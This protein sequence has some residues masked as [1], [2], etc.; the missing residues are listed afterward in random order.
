MKISLI[1]PASSSEK[2]FAEAVDRYL[3]RIRHFYPIEV[4]EVPAERGRQS[5]SDVFSQFIPSVARDLWSGRARL[6]VGR[7]LLRR[8]LAAL[9]I[10]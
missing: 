3:K 5:Q 1:W 6:T 8:S 4:V 9:G 2:D 7:R 10:N